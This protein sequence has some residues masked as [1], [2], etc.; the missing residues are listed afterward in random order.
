MTYSRLPDDNA[1]GREVRKL[2]FS[3]TEQVIAHTDP[4]TQPIVQPML[5]WLANCIIFLRLTT[6]SNVAVTPASPSVNPSVAKQRLDFNQN[7]SFAVPLVSSTNQNKSPLANAHTWAAATRR[8][9]VCVRVVTCGRV[10][11]ASQPIH[12]NKL[13]HKKIAGTTTRGSI[14]AVKL[15]RMTTKP[16]TLAG[17]TRLRLFKRFSYRAARTN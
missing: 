6:A 13:A 12:A 8:T 4:T 10:K 5:L 17:K 14:A 7:R 9:Q 16:T 2:D 11:A 3:R 15:N 1:S